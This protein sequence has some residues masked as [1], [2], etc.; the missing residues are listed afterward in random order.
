MRSHVVLVCSA[1]AAIA[2]LSTLGA[3]FVSADVPTQMTVQ[4]KLTNPAG[5]P[6]PAGLKSFTFKIYDANV[7]GTE[8]WPAAP[9]EVQPLYTDPDGLWTAQIGALVPLT[10]AVFSG[11]ERWLETTI[12]DGI[13]PPETL[14]RVKLNTNPYTFQSEQ[15][16]NA[17]SA[18]YATNAASA[19][20]ASRLGGL[21]PSDYA[22][23][24]NRPGIAANH[25]DGVITLPQSTSTMTDLITVTIQT[26]GS[27]FVVINGWSTLRATNSTGG[28]RA[29]LQ[30]DDFSGGSP[31]TEYHAQAGLHSYPAMGE[32]FFSMFV[33][34]VYTVSAGTYTFYLKA[35]THGDN[36]PGATTQMSTPHI[37]ATYYP[38]SY[39]SVLS[40]T[41]APVEEE[42]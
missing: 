39:G 34:R 16:R 36:A 2:A 13:N 40:G 7:G 4:G 9:G 29:S 11:H 25:Y 15:S 18:D 37:V 27:G 28:N 6:V 22:L 1:V 8:V 20:D 38:V 31:S 3:V 35:M 10:D 21:L 26:P 33:G 32:H 14:S 19:V 42:R 23:A 30:I 24:S 12:S 5:D 17:D 41:S